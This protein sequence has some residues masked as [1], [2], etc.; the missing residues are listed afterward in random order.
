MS[1]IDRRTLVPLSGGLDS[2]TLLHTLA[3]DQTV[4]AVFFN[5]GQR[6]IVEYVYARHHAKLLNIPLTVVEVPPFLGSNSLTGKQYTG[7]SLIVPSRNLVFLSLLTSM[8]ESRGINSIQLALVKGEEL[9]NASNYVSDTGW[10]FVES[11][12][13]F[14]ATNGYNLF[15]DAPFSSLS[16]E[17][18]YRLG[19]SLGV[20]LEET[21]S[22]FNPKVLKSERQFR[23]L[24]SEVEPCGVCPACFEVEKLK[25]LDL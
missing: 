22:C 12:N 16:K 20:K 18:V 10:G 13:Y 14:L 21:W 15:V 7:D 6:H 2:V 1:Q 9:P 17:S 19:K 25:S 3:K 5:Y 4:E 24:Q 23:S 8:A 11:F